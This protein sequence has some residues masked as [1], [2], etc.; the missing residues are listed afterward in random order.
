MDPAV[1]TLISDLNA[2]IAA[3]NADAAVPGATGDTITA[4]QTLV[5]HAQSVIASL[6]VLNNAAP[7]YA[8]VVQNGAFGTE[9]IFEIAEREL[10]DL[11]LFPL[12]QQANNLAFIALTVGQVLMIPATTPATTG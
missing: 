8:V 9:T 7:A 5:L 11:S 6:S 10:G 2:L 12:I 1:V 4:A 3:A